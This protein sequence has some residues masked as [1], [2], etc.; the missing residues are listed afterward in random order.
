MFNKNA[1]PDNSLSGISTKK[2]IV[3]GYVMKLFD[4]IRSDK[5]AVEIVEA[6]FVFPIVFFVVILLIVFGNLLYQQSKMDSIA[7]QGAQ[8]FALAY[9]NPVLVAEGDLPGNSTD[10]DV[11]PYRYLS[12]GAAAEDM[13]RKHMEKLID[14]TGTGLF[15]GM[16]VDAK[17]VVCDIKNYVVYHTAS[18]QIDYKI[19][20][21]PMKLLDESDIMKQSTATVVAAS[22]SAEFIRNIDMIMDYS[23]EFGLTDKIKE[24]VGQFK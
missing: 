12:G 9:T 7:V 16:E 1:V 4:K 18:V 11:K 24:L 22:D 23:E 21:F 15:S 10:V 3:R 2:I 13:A 14:K 5:G 8:Y 17:I 6:S 20:F 19:R